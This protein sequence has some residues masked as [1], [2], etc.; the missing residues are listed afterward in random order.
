MPQRLRQVADLGASSFV[1]AHPDEAFIQQVTDAPQTQGLSLRASSQVISATGGDVSVF[2]NSIERESGLISAQTLTPIWKNL[3]QEFDATAPSVT[4]SDF[5]STEETQFNWLLLD[6]LDGLSV[7]R[8]AEESVAALDVIHLRSWKGEAGGELST[9]EEAI[10]T[11]SSKGFVLLARGS[12][13]HPALETLLFGRDCSAAV[14]ELKAYREGK[15]SEPE[16][17]RKIAQS[18]LSALEQRYSDL[19]AK[20]KKNEKLVADI[21]ARL[22]RAERA[23]GSDD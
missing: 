19:L 23:L 20:N 2:K 16:K 18:N 15:D 4:L 1:L 5:V 13:R 3:E 21:L 8:D 9:S 17:R 12:E 14:S 22:S 7:L 10:S 11:L 6:R